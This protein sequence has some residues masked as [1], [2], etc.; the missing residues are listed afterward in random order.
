M[1]AILFRG[2]DKVAILDSISVEEVY[3]SL[4]I[5][6]IQL[7]DQEFGN[8]EENDNNQPKILDVQHF[9]D[10]VDIFKCFVVCL[11]G[12]SEVHTKLMEKIH[13]HISHLDI[14]HLWTLLYALA[15]KKSYFEGTRTP[16]EEE[17]ELKLVNETNVQL[18][19]NILKIN[20]P[21]KEDPINITL[22]KNLR[23]IVDETRIHEIEWSLSILFK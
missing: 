10:L 18:V 12:S 14:E 19:K 8:R 21:S 5:K 23:M 16:E 17:I 22:F 1:L 3:E 6:L 2:F 13:E 20:P 15:Y 7:I 11:E 4:E 9:R